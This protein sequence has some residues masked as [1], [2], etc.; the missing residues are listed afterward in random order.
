MNADPPLVFP[1]RELRK[2]ASPIGCI[3]AFDRVNGF[4]SFPRTVIS[5][6]QREKPQVYLPLD[7]IM[8]SRRV[9]T[10]LPERKTIL[11]KKVSYIPYPLRGV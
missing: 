3:L 1:S 8:S 2:Q 6:R 4:V 5:L 10:Q 11:A 7:G 9:A